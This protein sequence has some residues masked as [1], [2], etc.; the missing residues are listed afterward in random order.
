MILSLI[1]MSNN[2][3]N[4]RQEMVKV[5]RATQ[6]IISIDRIAMPTKHR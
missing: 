4:A 3:L 1:S 2:D 6:G 5:L